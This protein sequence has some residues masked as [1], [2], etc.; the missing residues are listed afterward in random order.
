MA[1]LLQCLFRSTY[2]TFQ[3]QMCRRRETQEEEKD[4]EKAEEEE[5]EE[6]KHDKWNMKKYS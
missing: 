6:E 5:K 1:Q 4:E 2:E 3:E